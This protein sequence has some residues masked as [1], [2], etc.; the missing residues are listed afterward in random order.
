L[1][2]IALRDLA[3]TEVKRPANSHS[4]P[5]C[6]GR[7]VSQRRLVMRVEGVGLCLLRCLG[8]LL[9]GRSHVKLAGRDEHELHADGV[10]VFHRYA[11]MFRPGY[12]MSAGLLGVERSDSARRWLAIR[13]K[14]FDHPEITFVALRIEPLVDEL[15]VICVVSQVESL[16]RRVHFSRRRRD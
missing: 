14:T 7:K 12:L 13:F 6:F 3:A 4:M 15:F 1:L 16:D 5:W 8:D 11:E 10:C 9:R 2:V